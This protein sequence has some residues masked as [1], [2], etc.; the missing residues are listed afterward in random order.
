MSQQTSS[1]YPTRYQ[2]W[3]RP[4]LSTRPRAAA[5]GIALR[6][7]HAAYRASGNLERGLAVPRVQFFCL[8]HLFPDEVAPFRTVMRRLAGHFDFVPWSEGV[9]RVLEGDRPHRPLACFSSDDGFASNTTLAEVLEEFGTTGCFFLNPASLDATEDRFVAHFCRTRLQAQP[10]RFLS[11]KAVESMLARGHEIGNHTLTHVVCS[12]TPTGRLVTEIGQAKALLE[13]RFGPVFHFAWPYGQY[14]HF[15]EAARLLVFE[16][17]H[18]SAASVVRGAHL[19]QPS[20][21]HAASGLDASPIERRAELCLRRD[22]LWARD[23]VEHIL[24]FS[25]RNALS[26]PTGDAF[27]GLLADAANTGSP[28]PESLAPDGS[29]RRSDLARWDEIPLSVAGRRVSVQ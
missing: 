11:S 20:S 25:A 8:H 26:G 29:R 21:G 19:T 15:S 2:D 17:G 9:R 12:E 5:R 23:P 4:P 24:Y 13:S 7:L 27:P 16:S 14:H 22:Q 6:A 3:R 1:P 28:G 18:I 10:T